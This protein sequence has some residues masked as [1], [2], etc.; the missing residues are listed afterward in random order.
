MDSVEI[1]QRIVNIVS[2]AGVEVLGADCDFSV[3]VISD[4]FKG[5]MPVKRQQMILA[6][7][8]DVLASGALHALTVKPFTFDEWNKKYSNLVQ[9][10]L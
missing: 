8:A 5:L 9:I 10:G 2:D 7:F 3:T 6:G 4:E 1:E